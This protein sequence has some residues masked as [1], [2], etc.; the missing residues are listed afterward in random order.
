MTP[1]DNGIIYLEDLPLNKLYIELQDNLFQLLDSQIRSFGIHKLAR[2]L[3]ISKRILCHWLSKNS[4]I[5]LD[6]LKTV[7]EHFQLDYQDKIVFIRGRDGGGIYN[8]KFPLDFTTCAG[9][10]VIAGILGDGGISIK[11]NPYYMNSDSNIF[12]GFMLDISSVLG[13]IPYFS[14]KRPR[15]NTLLTIVTFPRFLSSIFLL[16]GIKPGKKVETNPHIPLFIFSLQQEQKYALLSQF[17]DDEGTVNTASYHISISSACLEKYP[18][19]HLLKDIQHLLISLNLLSS[20]Y[21]RNVYPSKRGEPR[22]NWRL[23]LGGQLQLKQLY[24]N[25]SLRSQIKSNNLLQILN[26]YILTVFRRKDIDKTYF[27]FMQKIQQSKG[28]FTSIDLA[29]IT[30]RDVGSCR[31]TIIKYRKRN[32]IKCIKPYTSGDYHDYGQYVVTID[33]NNR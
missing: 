17:I 24:A 10:R 3:Q 12:N 18:E 11:L 29:K 1:L 16:L 28:Y 8:P 19:S 25:L 7:C 5:R 32:L 21:P 6:V 26:S 33:E 27:N 15:K 23:Q 9:V 30:G 31:N 13:N 20:I 14:E 22:R 2:T 4:L